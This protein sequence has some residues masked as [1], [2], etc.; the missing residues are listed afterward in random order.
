MRFKAP[1]GTQ[2]VLPDVVQEWQWVE[3]EFLSLTKL[4]GYREIRTPTFEETELFIRTSG[5]TSDVVS[6]EMYTFLDR[7]ERNLALKPEGTAPAMR[8]LIEHNLCPPGVVQRLSYITPIFR[9]SRPQKGRYREAHQVGLELV[10]SESAA[11]DAE[12]IEITYEFYRRVGLNDVQVLLN[13]IG[14]EQCREAYREAI[15]QHAQSYLQGQPEDVQARARKNSLRLLDSK[16]PEV[17]ELMSSGPSILDYLEP[18]SRQRLD[19]V[20]EMLTSAGVPFTLSPEIVR[21]LDYYTETVFEV[22]STQLGAQSS[23]CGGGRYDN[24]IR[25]LGGSQTPSVGVAMGIERLLIV[26]EE[27]GLLPSPSPLDAVVA[28]TGDDTR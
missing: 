18:D 21:G 15:L 20:C 3:Q 10:G 13:S 23:L 25:E 16:D 8:A 22:Q 19:S 28:Y 14:R 5:E 9:Y 2:D 24:L 7:G 6:K 12:V 4:Y 27:K 17:Q 1:R 26:L 11:A